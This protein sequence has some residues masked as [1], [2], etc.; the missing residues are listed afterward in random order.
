MGLFDAHTSQVLDSV[1]PCP[2]LAEAFA[3]EAPSQGDVRIGSE[4]A[5]EGL[6]SLILVFRLVGTCLDV[7]E[8]VAAG[9]SARPEVEVAKPSV[10]AHCS[11]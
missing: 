9:F 5:V 11:A 8:E 3:Q 4:S 6:R 2:H 7:V 1:H 10:A